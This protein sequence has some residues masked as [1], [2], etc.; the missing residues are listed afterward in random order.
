MMKK[1]T[2]FFAILCFVFFAQAQTNSNTRHSILW[3]ITGN[4][5]KDTSYIFG[6][7][8]LIP[9]ED[10]FFTELMQEKFNACK[11]LILETEI[12]IPL[13]QQIT[14]AKRIMLPEGKKLSDYM[15]EK[16]FADFKAY[17]IDSLKISKSTFKKI[18]NIKP[19]FGTA[20]ILQDLIGKSKTYEKELSKKAKKNKMPV[21]G[22][23]TIDYQLSVT[24]KI[25]I[26]EQ[27][28]ML[29]NDQEE[30][31]LQAYK[32]LIDMYRK[33]NI[34]SLY[35]LTKAD[36][37]MAKFGDEFI[38]KRNIA[39]IEK[40]EKLMQENPVFIAVGSGHLAGKKGVLNLLKE[41]AYIVEPVK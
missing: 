20:L 3:R 9:K 13:S 37:N 21:E 27:I 28:K 19:I 39:W 33:Q 7:I 32:I 23:E 40:I 34:D 2:L 35:I 15:S 11:K 12:D 18:Q 4:N 38:T 16:A 22:L 24:D 14:L 5:L 30:N 31:P 6:T 29:E 26:E 17:Y 25:S 1:I 10:Y 8:H 41:K 36:D